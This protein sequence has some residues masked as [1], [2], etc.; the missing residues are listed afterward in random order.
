[1]ESNDPSRWTR[2]FKRWV[3]HVLQPLKGSLFHHPKKGHENAELPGGKVFVGRQMTAWDTWVWSFYG[4]SPRPFHVVGLIEILSCSEREIIYTYTDY[5]WS[6]P[7]GSSPCTFWSTRWFLGVSTYSFNPKKCSLMYCDVWRT[8]S[9][10]FFF[11]KAT[12]PGTTISHPALGIRYVSSVPWRVSS[13]TLTW[14]IMPGLV[15][16]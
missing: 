12:R 11:Q 9:A 16:G 10:L 15:S 13:F 7:I 3:C 4:K 6:V 8:D 1:M 5:I 2:W 14:R